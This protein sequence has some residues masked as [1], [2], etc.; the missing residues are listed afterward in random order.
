MERYRSWLA[1]NLLPDVGRTRINNLVR[2]FGSP[3]AALDASEAALL[4]VEG[5]GEMSAR[6]I[7]DW[8]SLA[9]VDTELRLVDN[10]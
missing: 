1:L 7:V 3:E 10:H 9:D 5:I 4:A 6:S 2:H 8:R